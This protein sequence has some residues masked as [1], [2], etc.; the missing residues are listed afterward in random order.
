MNND[1][2]GSERIPP[3]K[4]IHSAVNIERIYRNV[5][6]LLTL[7]LVLTSCQKEVD[8][9][10]PAGIVGNW[11]WVES[12]GGFGGWTLTPETELRTSSLRI[13]LAHFSEFVNDTLVRQ[14]G[15]HLGISD[16]PLLG[17]EEKTFIAFQSGGKQ[18]FLLSDSELVLI[19]QCF[20][21]FLHRYRR[22]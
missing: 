5:F 17:S 7:S 9:R 3:Q 18:A 16:D 12:V 1:N 14:E 19:D 6:A 2:L 10:Q 21:C 15:Y 11:I 13:D 22:R 4:S 8:C 20:D